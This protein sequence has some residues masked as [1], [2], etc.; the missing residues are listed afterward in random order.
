MPCLMP[1]RKTGRRDSLQYRMRQH[2]R[3]LAIWDRL[4]LGYGSRYGKVTRTRVKALPEPPDAKYQLGCVVAGDEDVTA[5]QHLLAEREAR[6]VAQR[7][8]RYRSARVQASARFRDASPGCEADQP[9]W[10]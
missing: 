1:G 2:R 6:P 4:A 10:F 5:A 7:S 3:Y 9:P 8:V